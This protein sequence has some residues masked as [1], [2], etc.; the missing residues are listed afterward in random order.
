MFG[1]AECTSVLRVRPYPLTVNTVSLMPRA[2]AR[3][4]SAPA[5]GN[6]PY[7][8]IAIGWSRMTR[9]TSRVLGRERLTKSQL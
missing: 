7:S 8:G 9:P 1:T 5:A 6:S 3:P 2:V 4:S